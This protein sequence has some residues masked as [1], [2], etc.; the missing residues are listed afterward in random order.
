MEA[1]RRLHPVL[2]PAL[3]SASAGSG[4]IRIL[5]DFSGESD[6][7]E[8]GAVWQDLKMGVR[9]WTA[10]ERIAL[11]TNQKWMRDGLNMFS[12]AVPGEARAFRPKLAIVIH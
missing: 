9:N 1:H 12:W 10:W 5:L 3:D 4:K 7:M 6:G 8:A 2:A 11:V